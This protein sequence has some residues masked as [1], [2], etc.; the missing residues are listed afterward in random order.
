MISNI[1]KSAKFFLLT[2]LQNLLICSLNFNFKSKVISSNFNLKL[3]LNG[4]LCTTLCVIELNRVWIFPGSI[5]VVSTAQLHSTKPELKFCA[6]SNPARG[7]SEIRDGEDLWRR[8]RLEI[9]LNAFRRSTIP[10]KQFII[11]FIIIILWSLVIK[12][13]TFSAQ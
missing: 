5:L 9:K 10:Q 3:D 8:S 12:E 4:S 2:M 13:D 1:M 11:I 7:V 6:G